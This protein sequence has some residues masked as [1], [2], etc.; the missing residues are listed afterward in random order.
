[1]KHGKADG[2]ADLK[3]GLYWAFT[4]V[5][6]AFTVVLLLAV[7]ASTTRA[8]DG[9]ELWLR[10][11]R[12]ADAALLKQYRGTATGV[13]VSGES[14]TARAVSA[15]LA[16]GLKGLLG[17]DVADLKDVTTGDGTVIAGNG[18]SPVISTLGLESDLRT[19]AGEGYLIRSMRVRGRRATVIA[20]NTD[21]GVLYGAF[22][23]LRL[24]QT[25]LGSTITASLEDVEDHFVSLSKFGLVSLH[26]MFFSRKRKPVRVFSLELPG[27]AA[28]LTD[29][30]LNLLGVGA[31]TRRLTMGL[32]QL[33]ECGQ[34]GCSNAEGDGGIRF[35]L[36]LEVIE[37][38]VH[39]CSLFGVCS[40]YNPCMSCEKG[41]PV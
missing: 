26:T 33:S 2:K 29:P 31:R 34:E 41:E 35:G 18:R 20:A 27:A 4:V 5:Y 16:R 39:Y 15:E 6:R 22:H 3:V 28:V 1:M 36:S 17:A 19:L 38:S 23:F 12:V 8:E 25:N 14:A 32:D 11:H 40:H 9:Y 30:V 13:L 24:L 7:G 37:E 21:I 10:Y